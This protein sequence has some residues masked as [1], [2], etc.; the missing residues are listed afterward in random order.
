MNKLIIVLFFLI[1]A[2]VFATYGGRN[3]YDPQ[4]IEVLASVNPADLADGVGETISVSVTG[5]ALGDYVMVAP[6]YDTQDLVITAYVQAANAIEIR[7]QNEN[8]GSNVNLG[9]GTW[10][11][12][13]IK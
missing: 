11:I 5:A 6:P 2:S 7:I 1:V 9:N 12:R 4:Y 13:V 3:R 8:A 10:K